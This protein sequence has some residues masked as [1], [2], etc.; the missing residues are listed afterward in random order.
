V[1]IDGERVSSTAVREALW[2]G[3]MQ[4]AM[5]MLGR[6]YCMSGT[7]V[8]GQKLGRQLGYP[9][10]NVDLRRRQSPVMGIFAARVRGIDAAARNAVVS[11]GARPTFSGS[12][13]LL[14]V[15]L[16]DFTGDIYGRYIHVDFIGRIRDQLKFDTVDELVQQMHDDS[17]R[18][19]QILAK[20]GVT[21][22]K[23]Q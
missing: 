6:P 21:E 12:K 19:R 3:D 1:F 11:V 8:A 5:R 2:K 10:A 20:H 17:A 14:E 18:A 13:P 16:F 22:R 9:T 15:H 23:V 4:R 7:V